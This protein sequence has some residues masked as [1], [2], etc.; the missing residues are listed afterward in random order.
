MSDD[1]L[2]EIQQRLEGH[3]IGRRSWGNL[4]GGI[5]QHIEAQKLLDDLI[6]LHD[7]GYLSAAEHDIHDL[8]AELAK[9]NRSAGAYKAQ[10]AKERKRRIEA[11]RR[12]EEAERILGENGLLV[13]NDED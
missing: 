4:Y 1:T 6:W 5:G 11:V 2:R 10:A 13:D 12:L 7:H 3:M 8:K 9:A